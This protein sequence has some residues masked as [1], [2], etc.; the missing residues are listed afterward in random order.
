LKAIWFQ[1][2]Q[3]SLLDY[4]GWLKGAFEVAD[5]GEGTTPCKPG[6]LRAQRLLNGSPEKC[7][8]WFNKPICVCLSFRTCMSAAL[9]PARLPQHTCKGTTSAADIA[10]DAA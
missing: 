1:L 5:E 8:I 7:K 4:A 6:R 2:I 3:I 9:M 10:L